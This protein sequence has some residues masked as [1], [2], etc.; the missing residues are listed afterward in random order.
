[1]V[2]EEN[3]ILNNKTIIIGA[4]K[5]YYLST[6][7][8]ILISADIVK[9]IKR[10]FST[11]VIIDVT[12]S[13]RS[14]KLVLKQIVHDPINL[15]VTQNNNQAVVEYNVLKK[16]YPKIDKSNGFTV[17]KPIL[18]IPEIEAF[19]ME[20]VEGPLLS[21]F[22]QHAKYLSSYSKFKQL[23]TYYRYCGS[24]LKQFQIITGIEYGGVRVLDG[25]LERCNYR[26]NIIEQAECN[27]LPVNFITDIKA[28]IM[29][30]LADIDKTNILIAGAHGDFGHWNIIVA[31]HGITVLDFMGHMK[32]LIIYDLYKM[33]N[34][35]EYWKNN[36]LYSNARLERLKCALLK[37]YG[38]IPKMPASVITLCELYHHV[39]VLYACH[40]STET[41][42][43]KR[44]M[45]MRVLNK[46]KKSILSLLNSSR[47]NDLPVSDDL[48][49]A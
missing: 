1:M 15:S 4:L 47:S 25:L 48:I 3:D 11:I 46:T 33:L 29:Y 8:N 5:E 9:T 40:V 26:L 6:E 42:L 49:K 37:G 38:D 14:L 28:Y 27:R 39:C 7:N 35:F 32:E 20:Y 17:P 21:E 31:N 36:V 18:V 13:D 23:E 41:R 44:F 2:V 10:S 34:S 12:L 22:L 30:L 24:W 45:R 43:D 19:V 16:I